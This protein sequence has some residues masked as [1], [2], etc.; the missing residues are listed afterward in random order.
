MTLRHLASSTALLLLACLV[1]AVWGQKVRAHPAAWS[2]DRPRLLLGRR[3]PFYPPIPTA[4][5]PHA[6]PTQV[7][8]LLNAE[9]C[10]ETTLNQ[11]FTRTGLANNTCTIIPGLDHMTVECTGTNGTALATMWG[12]FK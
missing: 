8:Y 5:N 1:A 7:T 12:I 4:S 2:I 9:S 11:A 6:R 3:P 10:E